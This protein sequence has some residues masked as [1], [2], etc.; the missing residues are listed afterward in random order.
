MILLILHF[1]GDI[2]SI[3]VII[4]SGASKTEKSFSL[5][6]KVM[7]NAQIS[8]FTIAYPSDN[9]FDQFLTLSEFGKHY[10]VIDQ[11]STLDTR[12]DLDGVFLDIIDKVEVK[13]HQ[14]IY[15]AVCQDH[16]FSFVQYLLQQY[17][18]TLV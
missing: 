11:D 9:V 17:F 12:S 18:K 16:I 15:H 6:S 5:L 10:S 7:T 4:I 3:N 2:K 8:I 1:S 14:R 13:D